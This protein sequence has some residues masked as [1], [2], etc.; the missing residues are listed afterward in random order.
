MADESDGE[1]YTGGFF[2]EEEE[3]REAPESKCESLRVSMVPVVRAEVVGGGGTKRVEKAIS[4]PDISH[5]TSEDYKHVYSP[6][7][8]T[9]LMLDALNLDAEYLRSRF[10]LSAEK[11]KNKNNS[12]QDEEKKGEGGRGGIVVEVGVGS[13]IVLTHIAR[14]MLSGYFI[15]V[16]INPKAAK[17]AYSTL[18]RNKI[19]NFD[20][21]SCDLLTPFL[22]RLVRCID[23]LIFNPPYVPTPSVEVKDNGLPRAWAGGIR[24]REVLDRLLPFVGK[25]L[26]AKGVFYLVTVKENEPKQI[27]EMLSKEG[28]SCETITSRKAHNEHLEIHRFYR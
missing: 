28:L 10:A 13:G 22:S 27:A 14:L 5:L 18:R 25:L 21:V 15:G 20:I 12:A 19:N 11:M 2:S 17:C 26:S 3:G 7:E 24:G 8:D 1:S 6:S 16:D 9:F 4:D 23:V